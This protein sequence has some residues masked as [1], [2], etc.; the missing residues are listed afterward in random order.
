MNI[1]S[2]WQTTDRDDRIAWPPVILIARFTPGPAGSLAAAGLAA[3]IL[4]KIATEPENTLFCQRTVQKVEPILSPERLIAINVGRR[5]ED[6]AVDRLLRQC[7]VTR[8]RVRRSRAGRQLRRIESL[9]GGDGGERRLVGY[10]ALLGP[11]G[12]QQRRSQTQR[13]GVTS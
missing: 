10:V 12:A 11:D 8:C 4:Q 9:S 1:P 2:M 3:A 13:V 7:V 5:T 6:L